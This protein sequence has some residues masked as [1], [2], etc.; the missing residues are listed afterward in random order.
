MALARRLRL[1]LTGFFAVVAVLMCFNFLVNPLGAW[2]HRM[3]PDLYRRVRL[4]RVVTP[5][6]LRT[7]APRTLLL[8]S[9]RVFFGMKIEQGVKDGFQN[10]A[11]SGSRLAEISKELDVALR[12]PNLRRIIWGVEFYTFD[13][14][15]A[16]CSHDTCARLDG[17][18]GIKLTDSIL[19]SDALVASWRLL[20]RAATGNVTEAARMPIPWPAPFICKT[21]AHP[22][23]PTLAGMDAARRLREVANLPEY[24]HFKYSPALLEFF[25]ALVERI[26]RADVELI[27][28]VPPVSE[29]E[30]EMIRQTGRWDDFQRWKRDLAARISYADF[31]GYNGIARS[32]RMFIDA[33]HMEPAVG[34][35]IMRR[36]LGLAPCDCPDAAIV[37]SAALP[38]TARNVDQMLALQEQRKDAAVATTPNVYSTTVAAA[39]VKRYGGLSNPSLSARR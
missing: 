38:V 32:D 2:R 31:S 13:E 9:S 10:A 22:E 4:E 36:L 28:F 12:N 27:A 18:L 16:G 35:V 14:Y 33:W 25:T 3:V 30:M 21:F 29:Y 37:A 7:S 8:G 5:Y 17:E 1:M 26:R 23:P 34:A 19:S 15:S 11:F 6:L 24:R 39:I 20:V